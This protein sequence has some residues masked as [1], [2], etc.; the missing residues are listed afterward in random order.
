[1]D[2]T[3]WKQDV[4]FLKQNYGSEYTNFTASRYNARMF[5]DGAQVDFQVKALIGFETWGFVEHGLTAY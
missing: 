1:M 3:L 5:Q 4:D 2:A